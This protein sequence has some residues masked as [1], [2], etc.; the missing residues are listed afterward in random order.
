MSRIGSINAI[1]TINTKQQQPTSP[2]TNIASPTVVKPIETKEWQVDFSK[3]PI[4]DTDRMKQSSKKKLRKKVSQFYEK[5]NELVEGYAELYTNTVTK[6]FLKDSDEEGEEGDSFLKDTTSFWV[7]VLLLFLKVSASLLS[8]SL[9]VITSTIDSI[10][11]LVSGLILFYTNLLKKKKS[12]L[13]LYPAGKERLEPLGFII[14]ATCMST[15]SLQ[16]IKEGVVEWIMK[17]EL[18]NGEMEWMLGIKIPSTFKMVFYIYGLFVLFIAIVLKSVLYVLCIRAKDSPSCEAYAF[19]H[20]NDV[21]S[22]TFLIISLFVSQWVWWLDPFGA[23]LLSIYIIYGWVGESMEH[24]TKLVGLTAESEFIK[25]LTFI[26]VNQS[27]KIMKVETV[28]AWYS[29]M[30]IIA[31]IHVVLPP[32]MSLREA[33]NIGEDLQMKIE[34]VPEVERCFV[35]LDFNDNHKISK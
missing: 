9:S 15:A 33:H 31:E 35:H 32:N 25:K 22:N 20:R 28:T 18:L 5:Q 1:S 27:E 34:S 3:F 2:T 23:T 12:D 11:D 19:D 30:N 14:F 7:N 17:P 6:E 4:V 8:L 29:G 24:V 21:L 16:I 13:H 26:A 10:L